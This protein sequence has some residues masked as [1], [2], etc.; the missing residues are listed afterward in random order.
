MIKFAL[1]TLSLAI[2]AM[3][4]MAQDFS[5]Q[6]PA[7]NDNYN[8][9]GEK[10]RVK[11]KKVILKEHTVKQKQTVSAP[12]FSDLD[13]D[14]NNAVT[15]DEFLSFTYYNTNLFNA[16]DEDNNNRLDKWEYNDVAYV[17]M[18]EDGTIRQ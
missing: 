10:D 17:E 18:N 9:L 11:T 2:F 5:Q 7:Y 1:T 3:P 6:D 8:V 12:V 15:K 16:L 13:R 14:R 4:A